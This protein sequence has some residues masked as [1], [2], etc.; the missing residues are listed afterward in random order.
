V[1]HELNAQQ[2]ATKVRSLGACVCLNSHDVFLL[3]EGWRATGLGTRGDH[4]AER[5][6]GTGGYVASLNAKPRL[7][8][9][10]EA[11]AY[12]QVQSATRDSKQGP[13]W[14]QH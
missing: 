12:G 5:R 8:V 3:A 11:I 1:K 13:A 9:E 14:D 10:V 2:E 4:E 6:S 7:F